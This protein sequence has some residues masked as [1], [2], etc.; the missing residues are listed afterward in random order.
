[1]GALIHYVCCGMPQ[2]PDRLCGRYAEKDAAMTFA[3]SQLGEALV[4]GYRAMGLANL[5]LPDLRAKIEANIAAVARGARTKVGVGCFDVFSQERAPGSTLPISMADSK[6]MVSSC[7]VLRQ[8][9]RWCRPFALILGD[10]ATQR[11]PLQYFYMLC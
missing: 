9:V 6:S 8:A 1:M 4:G 5:W 10:A 11:S 7:L 3:P 2:L